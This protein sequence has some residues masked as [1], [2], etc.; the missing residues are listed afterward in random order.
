VAGYSGTPL[1]RKLGIE[2]NGRLA[3][4]SPPPNFL[5]S[6]EPLP[7]G[8]QLRDSARGHND[9]ILFFATRQAELQRRFPKLAHALD[10][11]GGLWIAWPKRASGVVT[12][13]TERIVREIGLE[14]GL[15]DNKVCAVD[16]TWSGLRFVYRVSDRLA[17][18]KAKQAKQAKRNGRA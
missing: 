8:V 3:L 15:V 11:S 5:A 7:D 9:V 1:P 18:A 6:L 10:L 12:D 17:G 13:L 16:D 14:G 4:V 2:A